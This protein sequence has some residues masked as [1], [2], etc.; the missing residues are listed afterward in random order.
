M[1][2]IKC[3]L[4]VIIVILL[5]LTSGCTDDSDKP[6]ASFTMTPLMPQVDEVVFF[7]STSHSSNHQIESY[8]WFINNNYVSNYKKFNYTF[9]QNGTY[10]VLLKVTDDGG[11]SDTKTKSIVIGQNSSIKQRLLG[12]WQWQGN[13]QIGNWTF[14]ANNTLKSVFRGILPS[15]E[16]GSKSVVYWKYAIDDSN[17][18]FSEP[19]DERLDPA[20]Y[21]YEFLENYTVLKISQDDMTANWYKID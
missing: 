21:D 6:I 7:N 9:E 8:Q 14:Y 18:Y 17:I 3:I 2:E 15:G 1:K 5:S 20:I 11:N 19:S 16:Y 10:Q 13:D 4:L 12:L